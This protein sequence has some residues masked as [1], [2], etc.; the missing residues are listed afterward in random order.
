MISTDRSV[1]DTNSAVLA[2]LVEQ[3][4]LVSELHVVV[5]TPRGEKFKKFHGAEHLIIHPT[6]SAGRWAYLPDA[7]RL[8][9][10]IIAHHG[11]R[12]KW[13]ITTQDP[14]ETG[15]LGYLIAKTLHVPLHLQIHTD[16]WSEAWQHERIMNRARFAVMGFLLQ[17]TSGVRVVSKRVEESVL[18]SGVPK[19]CVTRVP[20]FTD[21]RKWKET[22]PTFDLHASYRM[23]DK[24]VLSIGRL[25]PEK[26]FH[27]LIRAFARVKKVRDDTMLLIVG[28]GP[29]RERLL[30]LASSLGLSGSV[31]VLPWARDVVSYY[32]TCD[33]YVQP[34]L[35]EG[36]GLAVAEAMAAGA[37]VLMT[38]V[39]VAGELVRDKET[40]IVIPVGDE[41]ALADAMLEILADATLRTI[42]SAAAAR[43]VEQ[44]PTHAE[45]L[46]AYRASWVNAHHYGHKKTKK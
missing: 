16:P 24:I 6:S 46:A 44:L 13:L 17:H 11:N 12:E 38:D 5:F 21:V 32:K 28:S 7:F 43:E 15:A 45:T 14:F 42:L 34:S 33:L 25:Q 37:P 20:I 8:A 39:G 9:R 30:L 18:R 40:G 19:E 22:T 35:Y 41:G 10:S 1:F 26:N 23:F 2:R 36:W 27:G 3:A 29:L 31:I 4:G